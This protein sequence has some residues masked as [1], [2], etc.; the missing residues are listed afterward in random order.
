M[1]SSAPGPNKHIGEKRIHQRMRIAAGAMQQQN[2]IVH[3]PG[4]VAVGRAQGQV[5]QLQFRQRLAGAKSKV[6]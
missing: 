2:R 5:M 6:G 4:C 3:V 1:S